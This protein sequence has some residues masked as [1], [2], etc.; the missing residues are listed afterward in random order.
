MT[1]KGIQLFMTPFPLTLESAMILDPILTPTL[2]I[3]LSILIPIPL[4]SIPPTPLI[5]RRVLSEMTLN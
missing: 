4:P 1:L 2:R 3:P 5:N